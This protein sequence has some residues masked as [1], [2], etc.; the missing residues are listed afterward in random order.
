MA[1]SNIRLLIIGLCLLFVV[2]QSFAGV[3]QFFLVQNSG[4][5]Q[6]YFVDSQSHFPEILQRLVQMSCKSGQTESALAVFNQSPNANLSPHTIYQGSCAAMPVRRLATKIRAA[7]IPDDPSVFANSDYRQALSRAIA[8]YAKGHS[9]IF[10]MVTNNKNSPNNSQKLSMHD[11][12]FYDMLHESPEIARV[13]AL[14]LADSA[15]SAYFVSHGL[16][17]F[18]IAYGQPAAKQ[19]NTLITQGDFE[20]YFG[21][22]AASL[23]P[24][25]V[26]AVLFYPQAVTGSVSNVRLRNG[27]LDIDIPAKNIPQKFSISGRFVNQF[28]PYTITS[29]NTQAHLLLAGKIYKI[30]LSPARLNNLQPGQP[31]GL[32]TLSFTVP[33]TPSWSLATVFSSGRDIPAVL[34]FFLSDQRLAISPTFTKIMDQI[35]PN[36]P[37]PAIFR[38]DAQIHS[39]QTEVPIRIRVQYPVWPLLIFLAGILV[40]LA[41]VGFVI[42]RIASQGA[43]SVRVRVDDKISSYR[44]A[45]GKVQKIKNTDGEVVAELSR[46]IFGYRLTRIGKGGKVELVKK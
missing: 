13:I 10:W 27:V 25:N 2:P 42:Y 1:I 38:P 24:L 45:R 26:S 23:K 3:P 30:S 32:V 14:P 4:W 11:A 18:G 44:L 22:R 8:R 5:M 28:Y 33:A 12:A 35:L 39:S 37:M 20:K 40:L 36:A 31:S 21:V 16:I 19:L 17:V 46:G 6:P 9:A 34:Q 7:R 41:I 29:A 43:K 15:S